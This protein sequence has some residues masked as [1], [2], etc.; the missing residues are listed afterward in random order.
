[1]PIITISRGTFSGGKELAECVAAE[2]GYTCLSRE[3]ILEAAEQYDVAPA[4]LA[5]VIEKPPSFLS[6]LHR[7]RNQYLAYFRSTLCKHALEDKL[8]YHGLGGQFL[9]A[10]I[11]HVVRVRVVANLEY[12]V[13]AARRLMNVSHH[14]ALSHITKV[15]KDRAKWSRFLYG[16]ECTDPDHYDILLNLRRLTIEGA[17]SLVCALAR[18]PEYATA[19]ASRQALEDNYLQSRVEAALLGDERTAASRHEIKVDRGVVT[20]EGVAKL[21]EAIDAVPEV[22]DKVEGLRKLN[23]ALTIV[24][25]HGI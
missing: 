25:Y 3:V 5:A 11:D 16:E 8:V 24:S 21:Q 20:V 13:A 6:R 10:G 7:E 12:R 1:M 15:D 22:L 19:E 14:Q 17:C 18:L 4:A 9:L 23:N 2:L